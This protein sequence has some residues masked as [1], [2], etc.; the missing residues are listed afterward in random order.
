[1]GEYLQVSNHLSMEIAWTLPCVNSSSLARVLET[2]DSKLPPCSKLPCFTLNPQQVFLM[3]YI[4]DIDTVYVMCSFLSL[5]FLSTL[6][7]Y[8]FV[9]ISTHSRCLNKQFIKLNHY[10]H[11]NTSVGHSRRHPLD[12]PGYSGQKRSPTGG[13]L[14]ESGTN[15]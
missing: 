9:H 13:D 4:I 15:Q 5:V 1:M 12:Q 7:K 3:T 14:E 2:I 11:F 10:V 6:I 8:H